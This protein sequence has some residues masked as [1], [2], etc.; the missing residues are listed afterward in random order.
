MTTPNPEA[1]PEG[2]AQEP[3]ATGTGDGTTEP[4][5]GSQ[6]GSQGGR[7]L[8]GLPAWAVDEIKSLRQES[9]SYRTKLRDTETER[10]G[11]RD[12]LTAQR[13]TE[14]LAGLS[15]VLTDPEDVGRYVDTSQLVDDKGQPDP[16]KYRQAAEQLATDR[17]H[18]APRKPAP[19]A[20]SGGD[21]SAGTGETGPATGVE[22]ARRRHR[23]AAGLD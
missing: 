22:A 8:D 10:D 2:N 17:P 6:G 11:I 12:T 20:R 14:A 1:T 16:G 23:Q 4:A 15:T 19:P 5:A 21:F 18:L 9:G 7:S 13:R 3:P